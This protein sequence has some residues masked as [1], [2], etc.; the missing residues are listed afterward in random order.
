MAPVAR[1]PLNDWGLLIANSGHTDKIENPDV[2]TDRADDGTA[3]AKLMI[4]FLQNADRVDDASASAALLR[5]FVSLLD[6]QPWLSRAM[7]DILQQQP[8]LLEQ[9]ASAPL[10]ME[11]CSGQAP[12]VLHSLNDLD[13]IDHRLSGRLARMQWL[14]RSAAAHN[15]LTALG[16]SNASASFVQTQL[17]AAVAR[18][19]ANATG[20]ASA[21]DAPAI[22]GP[23]LLP[24]PPPPSTITTKTTAID[25]TTIDL[26]TMTTSVR[27]LLASGANAPLQSSAQR[28]IAQSNEY[29]GVL[30]F[31][32]SHVDEPA[33]RAAASPSSSSSAAAA[34]SRP[35]TASSA[36]AASRLAAAASASV[37]AS[38]R[39]A[40][41]L[42]PSAAAPS[43]MPPSMSAAAYSDPYAFQMP[44]R[45]AA[46]ASLP[47]SASAASGP[48][49]ASA[50]SG[51]S[52]AS[53]SAS[54]AAS[55]SPALIARPRAEERALLLAHPSAAAMLQH[56]AHLTEMGFPE[57]HAR[58]ALAI[59]RGAFGSGRG[60][61]IMMIG[62]ELW[63]LSDV[64][65]F[66][67][68][69]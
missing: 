28:F 21:V 53:A 30:R 3:W 26:T 17:G 43:Y 61:V 67:F 7:F 25:L 39:L 49:A 16:A 2:S 27:P 46:A 24:P 1:R 48:S 69:H 32:G 15:A 14:T 20:D 9:C 23:P 22:Y 29:L 51:P 64:D 66:D 4:V 41:S 34:S 54:A 59:S 56:V 19:L 11:A 18:L 5:V 47:S 38:S 12:H 55:A 37:S 68:A 60:A 42:R 57:A 62:G 50:A 33:S 6:S 36:S 65:L 35:A 45:S 63:A 31:M 44:L 58:M 40:A 13:L 10:L 8:N 52:A